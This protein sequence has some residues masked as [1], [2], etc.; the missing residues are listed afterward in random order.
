MIRDYSKSRIMWTKHALAEA[1]EDNFRTCEIEDNLS[2]VAEFPELDGGKMRGILRVGSRYCT[3]VYMLKRD[4]LL[5]ITCW[6]SNPTDL[7]EY[8]RNAKQR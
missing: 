2:H 1:T 6:E 7:E 3:L 4:G 5:M 8:N